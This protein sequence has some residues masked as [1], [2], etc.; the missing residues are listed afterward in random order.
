MWSHLSY[1]QGYNKFLQ[2]AGHTFLIYTVAHYARFVFHKGS[3]LLTIF[4]QLCRKAPGV[5]VEK[6]LKMSQ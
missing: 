3:T 6:K 2:S 5:L 1:G 4:E